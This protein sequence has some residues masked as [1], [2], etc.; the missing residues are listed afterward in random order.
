M[1]SR[2]QK[3]IKIAPGIRLNL[4]LG[5]VSISAGPRGA[6]FTVGKGGVYGNAGI[7]G[8]GLSYRKKLSGS[9]SRASQVKVKNEE[10]RQ[11]VIENVQFR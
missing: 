3:R 2:F 11:E 6:S 1:A 5:G 10:N 7:P 4:S 8:T 9:S